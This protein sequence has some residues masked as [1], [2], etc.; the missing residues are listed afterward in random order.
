MISLREE[1]TMNN[2]KMNNRTFRGALFLSFLIAST[3]AAAQG[4]ANFTDVLN[5][6]Q[7]IKVQ[8]ASDAD[9]I[10]ELRKKVQALESNT[11]ACTLDR[12]LNDEC[13]EYN[14]PFNLSM[15]LCGSSGGNANVA[16]DFQINNHNYLELGAG[17]DEGIDANIQR[18]VTFPGIPGAGWLGA[19]VGTPVG[20]VFGSPFPDLSGGIAA[21]GG[22][23]LSGC[24]EIP[25]PIRNIP[26]DQIIALMQSWQAQGKDLQT[27]ILA[28]ASRMDLDPDRVTSSL[29]ALEIAQTKS[30]AEVADAAL[31]D[32]FEFFSRGSALGNLVE[33]LPV[34]DRVQEVLDNAGV[35]IE[36]FSTNV[37]KAD[38]VNVRATCDLFA[39]TAAPDLLK[40]PMRTACRPLTVLPDFD[41]L[42]RLIERIDILPNENR[43]KNIICDNA[44]LATTIFA[45]NNS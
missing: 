6:I 2:R 16:A 13:G 31:N 34:G 27:E 25:V 18:S 32:P 20:F 42:V 1:K 10:T 43:I 4:Q 30:L 11:I 40:V 45:C 22:I 39:A 36:P 19:S 21:S 28:S 8:A 24:I 14:Q 29:T 3:G 37:P 7:E 38:L 9:K 44:R 15:S 33:V 41:E 23:G 17:W 5:K 26:R 12:F 35:L